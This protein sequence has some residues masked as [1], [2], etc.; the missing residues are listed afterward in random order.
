MKKS[1]ERLEVLNRINEFEKEKKFFTSMLKTFYLGKLLTLML[2]CKKTALI[3][4]SGFLP[5]DV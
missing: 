2:F 5:V 1:K 3:S 4:Q